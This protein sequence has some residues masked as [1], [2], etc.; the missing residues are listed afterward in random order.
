VE[1]GPPLKDRLLKVRLALKTRLYEQKALLAALEGEPGD[2]ERKF[3][4]LQHAIRGAE[5]RI[6]SEA[7]TRQQERTMMQDLKHL[8]VEIQPLI[9]KRRLLKR[10]E[11]INAKVDELRRKESEILGEMKSAWEGRQAVRAA[12]ATEIAAKRAQFAQERAAH[13]REMKERQVAQ[14]KL[15]RRRPP[16]RKLEE[17]PEETAR[18]E[19]PPELK[20][21][22][23]DIAV[24]K[25]KKELLKGG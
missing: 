6:S 18:I 25:G 17:E 20:I 1:Q 23:A 16:P 13:E 24:I 14:R 2:I 7:I 9:K 4:E 21:S 10:L 8:E 11:W 3:R 19:H 15:Q 22:L 12:R 5:F